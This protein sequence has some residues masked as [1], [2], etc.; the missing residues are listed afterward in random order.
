MLFGIAII[1][2]MGLLAGEI[3]KKLHLPSLIG[4][5]AV[6]IIAGPYMLD[7][8]DGKISEISA[9]LRKI[10]LIIILMRAGLLLDMS[11]L[12]K[13]GRPAEA[14]ALRYK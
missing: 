1:I 13:N 10:A 2:L 6:G 11:V 5:L 7:L 14:A 12:K 4:M 9:E 3:C 8:I